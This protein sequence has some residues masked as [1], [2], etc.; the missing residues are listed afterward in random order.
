MALTDDCRKRLARWRKMINSIQGETTDLLQQRR[1]YSRLHQM[2]QENPRLRNMQTPFLGDAIGGWYAV[3]ASMAIRRA[4]DQGKDAIS[5]RRVLDE[6][7]THHA[8]FTRQNLYDYYRDLAPAFAPDIHEKMVAGMWA[9]FAAA[10]ESFN[11]A[12]VQKDISDLEA[13]S[14][15]FWRFTT[16]VY[17][18]TLK[19]G[20]ANPAVPTFPELDAAIVALDEMVTRYL[21]LLAGRRFMARSN[22]PVEGYDWTREFSFAW[23]PTSEV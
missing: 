17:A 22:E 15:K 7:V 18:H 2:I 12:V 6:I 23:K 19:K 13:F 3:Y 8:C 4:A 10:G 20:E 1:W 9:P 14:R 5:M 11:L 16:H 21:Y